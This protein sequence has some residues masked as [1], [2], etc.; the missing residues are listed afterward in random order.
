MEKIGLWFTMIAR[1][2][3]SV[4]LRLCEVLKCDGGSFGWR[5]INMDELFGRPTRRVARY[6][7][8]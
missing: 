5:F 8:A 4:W 1:D 6:G 3:A 7:A 2:P